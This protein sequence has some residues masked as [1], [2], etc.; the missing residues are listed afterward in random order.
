MSFNLDS[1]YVRDQN[2]LLVL[3]TLRKQRRLTRVDLARETNLSYPTVATILRELEEDGFLRSRQA[4]RRA[5]GRRPMGVEFNPRARLVAGLDL[6]SSTPRAVLADLDG[7]LVGDVAAGPTVREP[8]DLIPAALGTL[9]QLLERHSVRPGLLL[10][11]GVALRGAL[12]LENEAVHFMEFPAPVRLVPALRERFGVPVWL[13]H[14]Y[15]SALLA[16]HLYGAARDC[17]LVYRVNVGTGISAGILVHGQIYRG[18]AGNAGEFGHVCVDPGGP[19]C[20]ACGRRGCLELYASARAIA[21]RARAGQEPAGEEETDR[22][23]EETASRA[24]QGDPEA[25]AIFS[26]A[27]RALACGLADAVNVLNPEMV[28][29]DGSVVRAYLPLVE[30]VQ[31]LL[32]KSVWPPSRDRL[33]VEAS[34]LA[35]QV[36]LRGA[37]ALVLQEVFRIPQVRSERSC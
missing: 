22:L 26:G 21:R 5:S 34:Q 11:V 2:R 15:N 30:E 27:A 23:V 14:N 35:G 19:E 33:R 16:E 18:A 32:A 6:N 17:Q 7:A 13:D 28:I 12:D 31:A 24:L 9:E 10:G 25:Q 37:V 36:M 20:S 29:I 1:S 3:A 4:D 8:D